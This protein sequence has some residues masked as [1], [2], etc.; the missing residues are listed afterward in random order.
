VRVAV[1]SEQQRATLAPDARGYKPGMTIDE[2]EDGEAPE[3]ATTTGQ[4]Y[5]EEQPA[6]A[7]ID[8]RDHPEND[9]VD[10]DD[11]PE[12][13]SRRD[14]DPGQATGNRRAAGGGEGQ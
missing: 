3:G 1:R 9:V 13:S 6:G 4:G 7:G 10:D 11:A 12:T 8:A 5:P 14:G 2:H